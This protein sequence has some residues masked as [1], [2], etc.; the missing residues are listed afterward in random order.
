MILQGRPNGAFETIAINTNF[1]IMVIAPGEYFEIGLTCFES[2]TVFYSGAEHQGRAVDEIVHDVFEVWE[3]RDL[4][5]QIEVNFSF[6]GDLDSN[7]TSN[8]EDVS[9]HV[10]DFVILNPFF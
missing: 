8:K 5:D 2:D 4:V 6:S 3:I 7:V 1:K 10:I 9:S